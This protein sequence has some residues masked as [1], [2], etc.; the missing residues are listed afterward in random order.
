MVGIGGEVWRRWR[1]RREKKKGGDLEGGGGAVSEAELERMERILRGVM[2][3][4]NREEAVVATIRGMRGLGPVWVDVN[5][6]RSGA[7]GSAPPGPVGMN[8]RVASGGD[9]D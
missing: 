1:K 6:E 3:A 8:R 5:P 2:A 9:E 7:S 4:E